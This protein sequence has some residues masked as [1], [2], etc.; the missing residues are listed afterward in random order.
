[1]EKLE[2]GDRL[3]GCALTGLAAGVAAGLNPLVGGL[4]TLGCFLLT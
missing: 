1:M 4:T 3:A 2:G